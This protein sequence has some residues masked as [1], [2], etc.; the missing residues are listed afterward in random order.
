MFGEYD[1]TIDGKALTGKVTPLGYIMLSNPIRDKAKETFSY[2]AEQ[3]VAIK[4]IS[5]DNPLTVSEVAGQAG[6]EG[7][8]N[9][10]DA[11]T[12]KTDEEI[13]AAVTNILYS[14]E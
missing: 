2:F 14:V 10:V 7:A 12:L 11:R 5:G 9:Y 6:I 8:Q 13:A 1:G 3:G 4:V